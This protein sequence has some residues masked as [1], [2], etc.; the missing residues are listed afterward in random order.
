MFYHRIHDLEVK[1]ALKMMENDIVVGLDNIHVEASKRWISLNINLVLCG[2]V[3]YGGFILTTTIDEN[4]LKEPK[5]FA[6]DLHL[7]REDI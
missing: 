3:D 2:E 5:R 6:H 1:E 4:I 7:F